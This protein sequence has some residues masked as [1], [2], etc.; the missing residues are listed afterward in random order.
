MNHFEPAKGLD[1]LIARRYGQPKMR[2]VVQMLT[3]QVKTNAPEARVWVT[4]RDER[5][6]KSHMDTDSQVIPTNLKFI[7]PRPGGGHDEAAKPR[8]PN[9]PADQRINCRCDDPALPDL[10]RD[11][12]HATDVQ[13]EGNVVRASVETK[14]RRAAESEAA[15]DG[16]GWMAAALRDVAQRL[17]AG[18]G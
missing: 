1:A 14:F 4:M 13:V 10:I 7:L 11:S 8:D 5:V 3:D 9:L 2:R 6:R 18:Q 17:R 16:G 15:K 12:I